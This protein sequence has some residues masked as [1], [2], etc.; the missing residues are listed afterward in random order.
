MGVILTIAGEALG[1]AER[2]DR[3]FRVKYPDD[4]LLDQINGKLSFYH[5]W[6]ENNCVCEHPLPFTALRNICVA[7]V[8]LGWPTCIPVRHIIL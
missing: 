2:A 7:I 8:Q 4:V 1:D 5:E 3:G 6:L